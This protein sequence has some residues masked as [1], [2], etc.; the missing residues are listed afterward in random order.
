[1][2]KTVNFEKLGNFEQYVRKK[3]G[4]KI[5][6]SALG[7]GVHCD[8]T[9]FFKL[10][11]DK[12]VEWVITRVCD[13]ARGT[14]VI[15]GEDNSKAV[16]PLHNWEFDFNSL[17]YSK[18]PNQTFSLIEKNSIPFRQSGNIL[19][20][21]IDEMAIRVPE[22]YASKD[23]TNAK[24]R[25]LA[26]AS[27]ELTLD[28]VKIV[29]DPWMIGPC[30]S[31]GWWHQHPP[32]EDCFD[33]IN[34]ADII[35]ISHNHPDHMHLES[36]QKVDKNKHFIIPAFASKATEKPLRAWGFKNLHVL[37]LGVLYR[38]KGSNL[39]VSI[40]PTGDQ[41]DDSA[42]YINKG[43]FSSLFTVDCNA[44]NHYVLPENLSLL[45]TNFASGASGWPIIYETMPMEERNKIITKNKNTQIFE[46]LQYVGITKPRVYVP[47]A[48][49]LVE[50]AKRDEFI[51][52]N[53]LKNSPETIVERVNAKFP[54]VI[55]I[56]PIEFDEIKINKNIEKNKVN[57][58]RLYEVNDK[59]VNGYLDKFRKQAKNF[60]MA[61][62]AKYFE[63]SGFRDDLVMYLV[64]TDDDF[65]AIGE[66]IKINFSDKGFS[67]EVKEG[68]ALEAEFDVLKRDP[69]NKT[70]MLKAR[71]DALWNIVSKQL[72]F[73]EITIGFQCRIYRKPD[74]YNAKFWKYFTTEFIF[75]EPFDENGICY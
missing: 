29:T 48:G 37:E 11:A 20:Y 21:E 30:F 45:M 35:Y 33:I 71:K 6:I 60:D 49:Y 59:Y 31:T 24:L 22:K 40:L 42:L 51:K 23:N 54:E 15:S 14:L 28:D 56:N 74:V 19:E 44:V 25:H 47:Y 67:S 46:I 66:S 2:T 16:C 5:D 69:E 50:E 58:K 36:L 13:H 7:Q 57:K 32:K 8:K 75:G 12:K 52:E 41:R 1:M 43:D 72:P 73:E 18:I 70:F 3:T 9:V 61:K 17:S 65:N 26:H 55:A 53:N 38:L 64:M 10:D 4:Q 68:K 63:N 39:I 62:V 27:L 34:G